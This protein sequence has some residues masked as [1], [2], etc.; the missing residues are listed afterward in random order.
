MEG[1]KNGSG[2]EIQQNRVGWTGWLNQNCSGDVFSKRILRISR[3]DPSNRIDLRVC[4]LL[5]QQILFFPKDVTFCPPYMPASH[6]KVGAKGGLLLGLFSLRS[7]VQKLGAKNWSKIDIL[8][9]DEI[10]HHLGWL[11]PYKWDNHHPWWCR[12]LSINSTAT[13]N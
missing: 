7:F 1:E 12:I 11:K 13:I 3:F 9:M 2:V 6:T 10:L 8:L 5:K 4:R